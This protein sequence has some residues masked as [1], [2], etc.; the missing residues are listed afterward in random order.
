MY[1]LDIFTTPMIRGACMPPSVFALA[2]ANALQASIFGSLSYPFHVRAGPIRRTRISESIFHYYPL[3]TSTPPVLP[4]TAPLPQPTP[5]EEYGLG[6][7][8]CAIAPPVFDCYQTTPNPHPAPQ[9]GKTEFQRFTAKKN[10]TSSRG[11]ID[12]NI[13][14]NTYCKS[15][16]MSVGHIL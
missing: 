1:R 3:L 12:V 15:L 8:C 7:G 9:F 11:Q 13:G 4:P 16:L 5:G 14:D 6:W 2:S 10:A